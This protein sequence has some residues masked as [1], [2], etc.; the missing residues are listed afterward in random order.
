MSDVIIP[1][2]PGINCN[3]NAH[4]GHH[5]RAAAIRNLRTATQRCV[6][7][8]SP[9]RPYQGYAR[10]DVRI[11]WERRRQRADR[12]NAAAALKGMLD[13]LVE[14]GWFEDDK[15]IDV[16]VVQQKEWRDMTKK[17]RDAYPT[18]CMMIRVMG[19]DPRLPDPANDW[20]NGFNGEEH[21]Q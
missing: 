15:E 17:E 20:K 1:V 12:S 6:S 8:A 21:T 13:G 19:E 16:V 4:V 7:Y 3:P 5:A 10:V 18:G 9:R 2:T 11:L 14:A